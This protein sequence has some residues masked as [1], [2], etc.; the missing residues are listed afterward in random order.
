MPR[1]TT[2]IGGGLQIEGSNEVAAE[3]VQRLATGAARPRARDRRD[4]VPSWAVEA[5][6]ICANVTT[7]VNIGTYAGGNGAGP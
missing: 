1:G 3:S 6:A 2:A 7:A 4:R 5:H